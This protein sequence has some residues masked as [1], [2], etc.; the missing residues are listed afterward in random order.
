M[1]TVRYVLMVPVEVVDEVVGNSKQAITAHGREL[2]DK[3]DTV[4][5][6]TDQKDELYTPLLSEA[7]ILDSDNEGDAVV[8]LG[9][10]VAPGV[11]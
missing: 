11:A 2:R 9:D 7:V 4:H 3:Y 1:P 6:M 8:D 5:S 10:L